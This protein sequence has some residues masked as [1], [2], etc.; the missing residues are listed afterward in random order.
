MS[1]QNCKILG[2]GSPI[3]DV[4]CCL[5]DEQLAH[6]IGEKS[7]AERC[8]FAELDKLAKNLIAENLSLQKFSGGS[9][10]NAMKVLAKLIKFFGDEQDLT[11]SFGG[12][13]GNDTDGGFFQKEYEKSGVDL[14][15]FI[16]APDLRTDCCMAFVTPDG[17]RTFRTAVDASLKMNSE[18]L[19]TINFNQFEFVLVEGYQLYNED[20]FQELIEKAIAAKTKI[21]IDLSA[22]EVVNLFQDKLQKLFNAGKFDI[23][24]ANA[25]ECEAF[26]GEADPRKGCLKLAEKCR[27][28]AVKIGAE[29]SLIGNNQNLFHCP[30]EKVKIADTT[31]AG[32]SW[33]GAFLYKLMNG[34]SLCEC[35]EFANKI[36]GITVQNFGA[37]CSFEDKI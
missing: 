29:G 25:S 32:E 18:W 12:I 31:G 11:A 5:S 23:V 14:K 27:I 30:S 9:A 37:E 21:A 33:A 16:Q 36:A 10:G 26:T 35:A 22:V 13:A 24:F 19:K 34:N 15:Y 17:E 20:F 8:S 28:A 1:K 7:T 2:I 6:I 3:I 4:S